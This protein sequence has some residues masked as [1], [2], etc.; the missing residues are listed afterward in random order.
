METM[1][2]NKNQKDSSVLSV[3][4]LNE[5][6]GVEDVTC[7]NSQFEWPFLCRIIAFKSNVEL[8]FVYFNL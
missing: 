2:V 3:C 6:E 8:V 4:E 5:I 7:C 1:A